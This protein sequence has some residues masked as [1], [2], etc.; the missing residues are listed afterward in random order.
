[1]LD[2][3]EKQ[4]RYGLSH[5]DSR[6]EEQGRE[7]RTT[8]K[9]AVD[10]A[11]MSSRRRQGVE[12]GEWGRNEGGDRDGNWEYI[13]RNGGSRGIDGGRKVKRGLVGVLG[14]RGGVPEDGGSWAQNRAHNQ[15]SSFTTTS[16]VSSI[17]S[18]SLSEDSHRRAARARPGASTL[19][20]DPASVAFAIKATL[21]DTSMWPFSKAGTTPWCGGFCAP[22]G[23]IAHPHRGRG[24]LETPPLA[25]QRGT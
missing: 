25:N 10:A 13:E 23:L 16:T 2:E 21:S 12:R 8:E 9:A 5:F 17:A 20:K 15:S 7:G 4:I 1:M 6:Q 14:R 19:A 18:T 22:L 24:M 3:S 11:R